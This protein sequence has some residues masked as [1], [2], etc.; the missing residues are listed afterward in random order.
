MCVQPEAFLFFTGLVVSAARVT[1]RFQHASKH[2]W[3]RVWLC[4]DGVKKC[5]SRAPTP[6]RAVLDPILELWVTLCRIMLWGQMDNMVHKLK[7][8][9]EGART[10]EAYVAMRFSA[11][12]IILCSAVL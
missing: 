6:K 4:R 3:N 12:Y 2:G 9:N 11:I 7:Q 10:C 1:R 8:G 5:A